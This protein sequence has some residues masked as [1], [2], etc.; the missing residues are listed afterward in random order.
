MVDSMF[1]RHLTTYFQSKDHHISTESRINIYISF[2]LQ[3]FIFCGRS[4]FY[5]LDG[6]LIYKNCVYFR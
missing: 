4:L 3:I 1:P 2:E 6:V 5:D